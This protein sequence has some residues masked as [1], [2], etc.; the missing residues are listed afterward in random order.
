MRDERM[1]H[2][3][4]TQ[5]DRDRHGRTAS[6]QDTAHDLLNMIARYDMQAY[7]ADVLRRAQAEMD[8]RAA[9]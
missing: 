7:M 3:T 8:R 9:E 6:A 1:D 2:I 5:C 4:V